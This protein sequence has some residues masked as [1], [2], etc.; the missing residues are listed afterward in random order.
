M[1]RN[2]EYSLI[3]LTHYANGS[4]TLTP[5]RP[6]CSEFTE[7]WSL[8]G[9]T[10]G[11]VRPFFNS[12]EGRGGPFLPLCRP[13]FE[14]SPP[15]PFYI[16]PAL[17]IR[18]FHSHFPSRSNRNDELANSLFATFNSPMSSVPASNAWNCIFYRN[19]TLELSAGSR[20]PAKNSHFRRE[21]H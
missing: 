12:L 14:G 19:P 21:T 16:S 11:D 1:K 18:F 20:K 8:K 17:F 10:F 13:L 7:L 6:L 15:P 9:S 4:S 3:N 2:T 5:S